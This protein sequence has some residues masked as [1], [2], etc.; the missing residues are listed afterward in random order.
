MKEKKPFDCY[1]NSQKIKNLITLHFSIKF[2]SI[3]I[4]ILLNKFSLKC[5]K[6]IKKSLFLTFEMTM[7]YNFSEKN[8]NIH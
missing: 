7:F 3:V 2:L 1:I 4:A 5:V 6:S 8:D